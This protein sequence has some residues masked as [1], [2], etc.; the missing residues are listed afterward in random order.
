VVNLRGPIAGGAAL[1][2]NNDHGAPPGMPLSEL[3]Q[4]QQVVLP[5]L[6]AHG[7]GHGLQEAGLSESWSVGGVGMKLGLWIMRVE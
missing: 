3:W 5:A 2:G 1:P 7:L 4:K 6:I